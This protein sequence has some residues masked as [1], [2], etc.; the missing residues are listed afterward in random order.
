MRYSIEMEMERLPSQ[1]T[2]GM[3]FTINFAE[4][5]DTKM[6][7][8]CNFIDKIFYNIVKLNCSVR[9]QDGWHFSLG[10]EKHSVW[11]RLQ[12]LLQG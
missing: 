8:L 10:G 7:I 4:K 11:E 6:S 1:P 2:I 9:S 3:N 12:E 5:S